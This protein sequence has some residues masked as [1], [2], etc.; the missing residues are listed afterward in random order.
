MSIH[1]DILSSVTADQQSIPRKN[2]RKK[3]QTLRSQEK[4]LFKNQTTQV[5]RKKRI[6]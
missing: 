3:P 4:K 6:V 1:G 5:K 2:K